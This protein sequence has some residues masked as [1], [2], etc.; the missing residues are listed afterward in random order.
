[1]APTLLGHVVMGNVIP[2]EPSDA[3]LSRVAAMDAGIP[4]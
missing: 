1:V 3:Y 2:T 4:Q